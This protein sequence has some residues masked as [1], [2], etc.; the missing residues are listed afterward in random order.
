[1]SALVCPRCGAENSEFNL[2]CSGCGTPLADGST[3]GAARSAPA[4]AGSLVGCRIGRYR[5]EARLGRGGMGVVYRAADERGGRSVALKSVLVSSAALVP[6]LRR[7]VHALSR[8]RHPG[9]VRIL[10]HGVHE[11]LPWY[12]MEMVQGTTLRR[13]AEARTDETP[14]GDPWWTRSLTRSGERRTASGERQQEQQATTAGTAPGSRLAARGSQLAD[15]LTL[16]RRLCSALAYLHGEGLVHR[17]LKPE[18]VIVRRG[19]QPVLVDFGLA[20]G[21]GVP[22]REALEPQAG[23]HGTPLYM[24]PEQI[25]GEAVDARADLY[26]LGCILYELVAGRPPFEA[27]SEAALLEAH[28]FREPQPPSVFEPGLP[29][30]LDALVLRLLEK[31]PRQRLGYAEDVAAALAALG[32]KNGARRK[33]PRPRSYLYRPGFAGREEPMRA[34]EAHLAQAGG[35]VLVAGESGTGKTRLL[36]ELARVAGHRGWRVLSGE[37]LPGQVER[38]GVGRAQDGSR[39]S[40]VGSREG[41][42][43]RHGRGCWAGWGSGLGTRL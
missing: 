7:E 43:A 41:A 9:I 30:G 28:L 20:A 15:A 13:W 37:C 1:M 27:T 4:G 24:A 25:Q 19:L 31:E 5:V 38:A 21:S 23:A 33:G 40:G 29:A 11:G 34:L 32:A 26:A 16:V 3:L 14:T 42:H 18:N 10:E 35:V 22:G 36:M 8:L 6:T 12:A 39:E 2:Q 17:D